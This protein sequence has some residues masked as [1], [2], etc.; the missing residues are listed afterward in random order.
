MWG[1]FCGSVTS[2]SLSIKPKGNEGD[3][4]LWPITINRGHRNSHFKRTTKSTMMMQAT[5]AIPSVGQKHL[6]IFET[7]DLWYHDLL[8]SDID[9]FMLILLL[10]SCY[11]LFWFDPF[12]P[13]GQYIGFWVLQNSDLWENIKFLLCGSWVLLYLFAKNVNPSSES[14]RTSLS[15]WFSSLLYNFLL[16]RERQYNIIIMKICLYIYLRKTLSS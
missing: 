3:Q 13:A 16:K 9:L 12:G 7:K 10:G 6:W 11:Q 2:P 1:A 8:S 15:L 5:P 4:D 14:S